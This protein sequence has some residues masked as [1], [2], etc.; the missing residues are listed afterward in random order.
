MNISRKRIDIDTVERFEKLQKELPHVISAYDINI[1]RL[2]EATNIS[3]TAFYSK[4]KKTSFTISEMKS[5]C[6]YINR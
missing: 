4:I 1:S 5:I 2:C 3:R 6:N